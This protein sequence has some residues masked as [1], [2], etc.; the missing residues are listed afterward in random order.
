MG[1]TKYIH[2]YGW[3]N[4]R[5]F[6]FFDLHIPFSFKH[7]SWNCKKS[8]VSGKKKKTTKLYNSYKMY[9]DEDEIM[10]FA[11]LEKKILNIS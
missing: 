1:E 2:T 3:T 5:T 7:L 11:V 6:E 10:K 9:E 8:V 4:R